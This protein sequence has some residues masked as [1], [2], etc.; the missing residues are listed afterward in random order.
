M[1]TNILNL[2]C[3]LLALLL[4]TGCSKKNKKNAPSQEPVPVEDASTTED[5]Q[6]PVD[7]ADS[8][9]K[10]AAEKGVVEPTIRVIN[11]GQ[12]PRKMLVYDLQ[13][14]KK[15]DYQSVTDVTNKVQDLTIVTPRVRQTISVESFEPQG[16]A[17]RVTLR[18]HK[19]TFE[20]LSDDPL[21]L[22]TLQAME[23]QGG[24]SGTIAYNFN[25]YGNISAFSAVDTEADNAQDLVMLLNAFAANM[26]QLSAVL[27]R[28]A[29][30]VGAEWTQTIDF[31]MDGQLSMDLTMHYT[32]EAVHDDH[33]TVTFT[34]D[35]PELGKAIRIENDNLPG[36]GLV[37]GSMHSKGTMDIY[38]DQLY[39]TSSQT[40]DMTMRFGGD[41]EATPFHIHMQ[42]AMEKL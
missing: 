7:E 11:N 27:P 9:E 19:A 20:K 4:T 6:A 38:F 21:H 13:N 29:L 33:V 1:T 26:E 28:E 16:D 31:K 22:Q 39:P 8:Q 2:C 34:S 3:V 12:E 35:I 18:L 5:A 23:A 32:L 36:D 24:L 25:Q 30:G 40:M 17:L 15:A 42:Q 10:V 14:M 37:E 41:G